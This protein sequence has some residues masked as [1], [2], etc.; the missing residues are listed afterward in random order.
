MSFAPLSP[1]A[2]EEFAD[3]RNFIAGVANDLVGESS[4]N[5]TGL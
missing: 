3:A 1:A 5:Q 4:L 2:I